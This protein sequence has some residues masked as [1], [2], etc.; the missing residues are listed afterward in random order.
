MHVGKI[1]NG[2]ASRWPLGQI[3][4]ESWHALSIH[5]PEL[6]LH[7][8]MVM[9][10]HIHGIIEILALAAAPLQGREAPPP[11]SRAHSLSAVVRR[12]KAEVTR[13]ARLELNWPD[14]IWQRNYYDRVIRDGREFANA[15]R[16]MAENPV[17]W[18][19][20]S[21]NWAEKEDLR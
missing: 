16:Y 14:E 10:N 4:E 6:R 19:A 20:Q 12:F 1:L 3:V 2:V 5:F 11:T 17:R 7:G 18:T 9:P 8:H 21:Q 15:M 13:R